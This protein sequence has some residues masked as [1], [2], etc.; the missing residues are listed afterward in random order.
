MATIYDRAHPYPIWICNYIY[1][2]MASINYEIFFNTLPLDV[3]SLCFLHNGR[4][5]ALA[6]RHLV[7]IHNTSLRCLPR[8]F[9]VEGRT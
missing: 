4:A 6:S 1:G 9:S 8:S 3:V 5:G 7:L 2:N